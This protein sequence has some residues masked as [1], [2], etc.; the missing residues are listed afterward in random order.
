MVT[1]TRQREAIAKDDIDRRSWSARLVLLV[2]RCG[3]D[4]THGMRGSSH[5][6]IARRASLLRESCSLLCHMHC[7]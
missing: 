1:A 5:S 7:A 6:L 3:A 4:A 2:L